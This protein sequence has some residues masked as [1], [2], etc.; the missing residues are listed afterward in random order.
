[1]KAIINEME[2][3]KRRYNSK[4]PV[5]WWLTIWKRWK[6]SHKKTHKLWGLQMIGR[7]IVKPGN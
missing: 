1:V 4:D 6:S 5:G 7:Y 3:E 2:S